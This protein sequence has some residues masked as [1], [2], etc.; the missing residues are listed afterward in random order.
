MKKHINILVVWFGIFQTTHLL[1][2]FFGLSEITP[3]VHSVFIYSSFQ[4]VLKNDLA[5][6]LAI[7]DI[8]Y[9][10]L[11]LIFVVAYFNQKRWSQWLGSICLALSLN[12]ILLFDYVALATGAWKDHSFEFIYIN[13]GF[14]PV[15]ILLITFSYYGIRNENLYISKVTD[16]AK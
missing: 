3:D 10:I 9:S 4:H 8:F 2:H 12:S 14:I 11:S 16:E 15:L 5:F 7:L 13:V 6:S 1:M